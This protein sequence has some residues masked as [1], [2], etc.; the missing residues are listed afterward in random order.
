MSLCIFIA[1]VGFQFFSP[2][3]PLY[4]RELGV[5]D[6][7]AVALWSGVLAAVL[8]LHDGR[9]T[10]PDTLRAFCKASLAAFKVPQEFRVMRRDELP[11]TATGKVQ[12]FRLAEM[13]ARDRDA[14]SG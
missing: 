12:K 14:A 6:P 1:F 9:E 5:T 10:A 8:V 4:I 13:L 7:S 3:L 2:F 11:V